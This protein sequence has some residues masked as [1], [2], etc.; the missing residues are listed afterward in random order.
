MLKALKKIFLACLTWRLAKPGF[1]KYKLS[2]REAQRRSNLDF[3]LPRQVNLARN[4]KV[5]NKEQ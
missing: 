5:A 2:L 4:D 1:G 3:G